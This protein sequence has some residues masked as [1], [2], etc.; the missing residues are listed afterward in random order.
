MAASDGSGNLPY[1]ECT[2]ILA[3]I[4]NGSLGIRQVAA[5]RC[6]SPDATPTRP[7]GPVLALLFLKVP[8]AQREAAGLKG[9]AAAEALA[10][11]L[12]PLSGQF[13]IVEP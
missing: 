6:G 7:R 5:T 1:R 9:A 12:D 13:N 10:G 11:A 3:Q 2:L 8:L 4:N